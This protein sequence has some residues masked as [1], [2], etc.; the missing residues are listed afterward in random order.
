MRFVVEVRGHNFLVHFDGEPEPRV[1]GFLTQ[2]DVEADD[3][4]GAET[5][6]IDLLRRSEKLCDMVRN[7]PD[8]PPRLFVERM[9]E[10]E[11]GPLPPLT[12]EPALIWFP[13]DGSQDE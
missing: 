3:E 11:S 7:T 8:D 2:V 6:A 13:E 9:G 4:D 10:Y 12:V 1:H 5:A